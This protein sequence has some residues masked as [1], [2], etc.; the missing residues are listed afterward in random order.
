MG[1]Q[2]NLQA[3]DKAPRVL[4]ITNLNSQ[5]LHAGAEEYLRQIGGVLEDSSLRYPGHLPSSEDISGILA[6]CLTVPSYLEWVVARNRPVVHMLQSTLQLPGWPR[7]VQDLEAIGRMGAQH[8]LTLGDNNLA[9][10]R[11]F[12][13]PEFTACRDGFVREVEAQGRTVHEI[14]PHRVFSSE[15]C[16]LK[17][18]RRERVQWLKTQ[19]ASL[20]LPLAV[21][22]DDDVYALDLVRAAGELGLRIPEDLAILG[23]DDQPL[24]LNGPPDPIS[25]I[26]PDLLEI[27]RVSAELLHR[28]LQGA[29]PGSDAVPMLVKIPPK[30]VIV[31]DSTGTFRCDHPGVTAAALFIRKHFHEGIWVSDVAAHARMSVRTLQASYPKRVGCTVKEDIQ[32]QRLRRAQDL[33]ETT[34]LKLAAVALESGFGTLENL[35]RVFQSQHRI[36]PHAWRMQ[37]RRT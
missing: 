33:L 24:I 20:P 10:Y 7:V 27:G 30:G 11:Y 4:L 28:M 13:S 9:F 17:G 36:T 35:C 15:G 16:E 19:L 34:D 32:R 1:Y 18:S 3:E 2:T 29:A 12:D 37:Q 14:G 21:M 25:S 26:D 22:A 6:C 5:E 8:L 23:V 31:G